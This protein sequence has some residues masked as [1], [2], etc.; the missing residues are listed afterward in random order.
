MISHTT[1]QNAAWCGQKDH[2]SVSLN[3]SALLPPRR[4]DM[5]N[6]RHAEAE[7]NRGFAFCAPK[8]PRHDPTAAGD[9]PPL[10]TQ[11]LVPVIPWALPFLAPNPA[12]AVLLGPGR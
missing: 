2:Q 6:N 4:K 10:A 12:R 3:Q 1:L 7:T 5:A 9:S 8:L 11:P